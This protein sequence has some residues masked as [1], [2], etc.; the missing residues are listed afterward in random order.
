MVTSPSSPR[1]DELWARPRPVRRAG[2]PASRASYDKKMGQGK[3]H[4]QTLLR[5]AR[6]RADVLFAMLRDGTFY[7]PRP[8]A[9]LI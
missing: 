1:A 7:E 9:T 6:R 3:H 8:T 5:L 2:A 4:T